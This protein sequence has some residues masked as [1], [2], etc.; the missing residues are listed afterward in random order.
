MLP[1]ANTVQSYYTQSTF[2]SRFLICVQGIW[3]GMIA[4]I[5]LQTIIL[6]VITAIT[7]WESEAA[8]AEGR[9]KKWGGSSGRH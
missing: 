5:V 2:K 1:R 9:V 6:V 3:T 7:D 8:L 4:G